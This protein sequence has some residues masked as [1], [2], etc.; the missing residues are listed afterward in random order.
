MGNKQQNLFQ[1]LGKF[2]PEQNPNWKALLSAIGEIDDEVMDQVEFVRNNLLWTTAKGQYLDALASNHGIKRPKGAGMSDKRFRKYAPIMAYAPKQVRQTIEQLLEIFYTSNLTSAFVES[3][4]FETCFIKDGWILDYTVDDIHHESIVFSAEYFTDLSSA[5]PEE[6]ATCITASANHSYADVFYNRITKQK[7]LRLYSKT[8]GV[9]SSIRINSGLMIYPM[10]FK[11]IINTP[12]SD[13][14][15]IHNGVDLIFQFDNQS[16]NVLSVEPDDIFLISTPELEVIGKVR[17]VFST[18]FSVTT[19]A[20]IEV[21]SISTSSLNSFLSFYSPSDA[22][23]M[24]FPRK[25]VLWEVEQGKIAIEFPATP[26][27]F[28]GLAGSGHLSGIVQKVNSYDGSKL[29]VQDSSLFPESGIV[30]LTPNFSVKQL[31]GNGIT[32]SVTY[33]LKNISYQGK[34]GNYLLNVDIPISSV[35]TESIVSIKRENRKLIIELDNNPFFPGDSIIIHGAFSINGTFTVESVDSNIVYI[36]SGGLDLVAMSG[37]FVS[38]EISSIEVTGS[39]CYLC[40]AT[41]G[42]GLIGPHVFD[43][44]V[45]FVITSKSFK[46]KEKVYPGVYA[47]SLSIDSNLAMSDFW[48]ILDFGKKNQE[49]PI[50]AFISQGGVVQ[51]DTSYIYK[52]NHDES[53]SMTVVNLGSHIVASDGKDIGLYATD[54]SIARKEIQ[55]AIQRLTSAGITID[56][57][58]LYRKLVYCNFDVDS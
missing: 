26:P 43:A 34:D 12:A 38:K 19:N 1:L 35:I 5:T 40:S 13:W 29:L 30:R 49:G 3:T 37:G 33:D 50:K 7:S 8:A 47:S 44:N 16:V 4:I 39:T 45:P 2:R 25:A 53:S 27:V 15:I 10:Q 56:W 21:S 54:P 6:I 32:Y 46:L 9:N 28:R 20:G 41:P 36:N 55:K 42:S 17:E 24:N 23:L 14:S 31:D 58:L 51:L 22:R 11:G 57:L 48:A 52:Y 18:H